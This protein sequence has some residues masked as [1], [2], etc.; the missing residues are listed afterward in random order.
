DL[1]ECHGSEDGRENH[2]RGVDV[3]EVL[4]PFDSAAGWLVGDPGGANGEV[5]GCA[6]HGDSGTAEADVD[7]ARCGVAVIAML[8]RRSDG[9]DA[10]GGDGD[11]GDEGKPLMGLQ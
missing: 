4:V 2:S 10:G 5:C 1:V 11:D 6:I 8:R 7:V 3:D 9:A